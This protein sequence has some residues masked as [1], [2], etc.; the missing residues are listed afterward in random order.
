MGTLQYRRF[1]PEPVTSNH[2]S[3]TAPGGSKRTGGDDHALVL[4]GGSLLVVAASVLG[5]IVSYGTLPARLRIHWTLGAGPYYGPEFAPKLL[6]LV[7]FPALVAGGAIVGW[8]AVR[9]LRT[10]EEFDAVRPYDA[11]VV[12]GTLVLLLVSQMAVVLAN[13]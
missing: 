2:D 9:G 8:L 12:V 10:V 3:A 7:L 1:V 4:T 5:S 6:V 11:F 13:I